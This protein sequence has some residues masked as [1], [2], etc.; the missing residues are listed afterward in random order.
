MQTFYIE[1]FGCQMNAHDSEKVIGTLLSQ[2]YA[3]V[4]NAG[5]GRPG[6]LQHLQ[7]SRQGRA[8][9]VSIACSSSSATARAKCSA[10]WAASRSRKASRSS[11]ARRTSA[12]WPDRPATPSCREMLVQLEAG[13]RRVTGL[14]L[15]TDEAFD[16]PFTAPRQSASRLHHHHRRLRQ[17]VRL[18]RGAVHARAG[19][20]PHQRK[21]PERSARA[22]AHGLHRNS[23]AGPERQQLSR[24]VARRLGFRDAA[25][26]AWAKWPASGACASPPRIRA[27]SS[28][29][30]STPSTPT[31]CSAITSIC[32]CSPGLRSVL[33][34]H[35]APLHARRI[36]APHR[37]DEEG[38]PQH[39]HHHRHHRGFPGRDRSGFR[40]RRS[41]CSTKC[42][43]DSLFSF[44]YSPPP[45]HRR[46]AIWKTIFREEEKTRRL[47]IVQEK[48]RAIQIRR[49][50]ELVGNDR[51]GLRGRLQSG[52][53][54][55]DRP[56]LAKPHA[57]FRSSRACG[58]ARRRDSGRH[59]PGTCA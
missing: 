10:F 20:Q 35:A 43:Y 53:G 25:A 11:S 21:R 33:D 30:S 8:E 36:H 5:R 22:G 34:A 59:V 57:Q 49:N 44:K 50:S 19:A 29:T 26:R 24:S 32:R 3:Q 56:H 41:R 15:D 13:N 47:A 28:R 39:L 14:S 40:S 12:W 9:G 38:A 7:H 6:S 2:G 1:T 58:A 48:Q 17:I 16:T 4:A 52:H 46:A 37:V 18:L 51:R 42:E 45:Q 23:A 54:P 55:M 31:R 27:I